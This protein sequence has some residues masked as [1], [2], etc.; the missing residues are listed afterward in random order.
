VNSTQREP[1]ESTLRSTTLNVRHNL[2]R[3]TGTEAPT[4]NSAQASP[5]DA[6]LSDASSAFEKKGKSDHKLESIGTPDTA[7]AAPV[8]R[9]I[10][11][12]GR[13]GREE[14]RARLKAWRLQNRNDSEVYRGANLGK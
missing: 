13:R 10:R 12:G 6:E 3:D 5:P 4:V 11:T 9:G 8:L 14:T 1:G 2:D 7:L